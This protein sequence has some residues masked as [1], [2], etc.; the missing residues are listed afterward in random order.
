MKGTLDKSRFLRLMEFPTAWNRWRM[1]PSSLFR[2][3]L[4]D[5]EPGG[6]QAAEHFRYGAFTW[7]LTRRVSKAELHKLIALTW[8]DPDQHMAQNARD[9]LLRATMV[10]GELR[11]LLKLRI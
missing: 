3:Q 7:W 9:D 2:I 5:Y 6:E 8:L 4:A 11:V 1:Y 10:R